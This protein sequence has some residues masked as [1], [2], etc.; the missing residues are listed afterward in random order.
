M[1]RFIKE[2]EDKLAREK[3][4]DGHD[5]ILES[6][7]RATRAKVSMKKNQQMS[8]KQESPKTLKAKSS[9]KR[10]QQKNPL[11]KGKDIIPLGIMVAFG[12]SLSSCS[13]MGIHDQSFECPPEEGIKC[14]ST[15][16]INKAAD[17]LKE[18]DWKEGSL[19]EK[20][21]DCKTCKKDTNKRPSFPGQGSL[22][23]PL[24]N[25]REEGGIPNTHTSRGYRRTPEQT[26][27]IWMAPQSVED[28]MVEET[29]ARIVSQEAGWQ[30]HPARPD[31]L[32]VRAGN[33]TSSCVDEG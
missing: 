18:K 13:F 26:M 33:H 17:L 21:L 20:T 3:T 19:D 12:L 9:I 11:K 10:S 28:G 22:R 32:A 27:R 29:Y 5:P 6:L 8:K 31:D 7:L 25:K 4:L 16:S 1:N 30:R 15:S 23:D 24:E 14:A 2:L